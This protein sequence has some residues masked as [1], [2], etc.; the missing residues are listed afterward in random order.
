[1]NKNYSEQGFTLI[2]L[3][4]VIVIIGI[5]SGVLI[6]VINPVRQQNRAR[7]SNIVAAINKAAFAINTARAGRGRLPLVGELTT[8]LENV[9]VVQDF[10]ADDTEL[11]ANIAVSGTSLPTTCPTD[12]FYG[13]GAPGTGDCNYRVAAPNVQGAIFR[14]IGKAWKENPGATEDQ[15]R[16]DVYVYCSSQ[17]FFRCHASEDYAAFAGDGFNFVIDDL[18]E[19]AGQCSYVE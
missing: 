5:L 9:S 3:L 17:G 15:E 16:S 11:N 2:E 12:G 4:I 1:M 7:N 14:I 6:A 18:T 10:S 19:P 8:E 13:I